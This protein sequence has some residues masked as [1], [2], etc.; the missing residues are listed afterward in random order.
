M[1]KLF[2]FHRSHFFFIRNRINLILRSQRSIDSFLF[3]DRSNREYHAPPTRDFLLLPFSFGLGTAAAALLS[4]ATPPRF[5][6]NWSIIFHASSTQAPWH[7]K[8]LLNGYS[9]DEWFPMDAHRL[10]HSASI[11]SLASFHHRA[12]CPPF[13]TL[14]V[15]F[16]IYEF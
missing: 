16:R 14:H 8:T 9:P 1:I 12:L 4:P 2:P 15:C 13:E 10:F 3:N 7:W 11:T 6:E 5:Q